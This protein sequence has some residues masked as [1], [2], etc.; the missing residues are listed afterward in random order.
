[1]FQSPQ[2]KC[3]PIHGS[4]MPMKW[5]FRCQ[6]VT[7]KIFLCNSTS[8][9]SLPLEFF[10]CNLTSY[11]FLTF[12]V[13][14][15]RNSKKKKPMLDIANLWD[16]D[17]L[18]AKMSAQTEWVQAWLLNDKKLQG[19]PEP[20][21]LNAT[22]FWIP[23]IVGKLSW[24]RDTRASGFCFLITTTNNLAIGT[25]TIYKGFRPWAIN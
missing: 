24:T 3:N 21:Y 23:L 1:M 2:K 20:W 22:L 17:N 7:T 5:C 8:Y 25:T 12:Q 11:L 13:A 16:K 18:F 15:V 6:R 4:N 10:L 9:F 19:H 14:H